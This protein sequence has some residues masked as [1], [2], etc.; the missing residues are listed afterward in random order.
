M[1]YV[2]YL[3]VGQVMAV[4]FVV[5]GIIESLKPAVKHLNGRKL[6]YLIL[7]SMLSAW[8]TGIFLLK[9]EVFTWINWGWMFPLVF[10]A[11]NLYAPGFKKLKQ[12]I[13]KKVE[14]V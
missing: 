12:K 7:S 14:S 10:L 11:A 4:A 9:F 1:N 3:M 6:V 5:W 2:Q 13:F 8:L